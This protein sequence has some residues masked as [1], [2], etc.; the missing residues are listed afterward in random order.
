M[1]GPDG[2][3]A[4]ERCSPGRRTLRGMHRSR[5]TLPLILSLALILLTG[6][7]VEAASSV[8]ATH[9]SRSAPRVAL[10]FDDGWSQSACR[11]IAQ[12]LRAYGATATFFI[13]GYHLRD[14]PEGWRAILRGFPVA[15]HTFSHPNLARTDARGIEK[16]IR[17]NERIHEHVLGRPMLKILRPPFG[18][19]DSEVLRVAGALGYRTTLLWDISAADTSSYAT[20]STTIRN[21]SRGTSGSVVL[22][23]CGPASTPGAVASIIRSYRSRGYRLVGLG[24]LFPG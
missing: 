22:M 15:N 1:S 17:R 4:G 9:G 18:A 24:E 6:F 13:N 19:Y 20:V 8:V 14:D 5:G 21:A 16:Q 11:S 23:H 2:G 12:T 3:A 7:P 10:T